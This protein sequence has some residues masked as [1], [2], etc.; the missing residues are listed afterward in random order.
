MTRLRPRVDLD[1]P[2]DGGAEYEV[3]RDPL[4]VGLHADIGVRTGFI[5]L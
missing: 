5:A 4:A 2:F 3:D 1:A